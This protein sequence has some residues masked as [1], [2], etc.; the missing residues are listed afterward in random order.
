MYG[1]LSTAKTRNW[2]PGKFELPGLFN[3]LLSTSA[4][5][6]LCRFCNSCPAEL[7]MIAM[8]LKPRIPYH[9]AFA[10]LPSSILLAWVLY[11]VRI[12]AKLS[13]R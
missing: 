1:R 5:F 2:I 11:I 4:N 6:K 13:S 10:H 8:K 9:P 3:F 12:A 7:V